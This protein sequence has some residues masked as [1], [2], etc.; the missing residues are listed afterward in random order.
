MFQVQIVH[1]EE[2]GTILAGD[3]YSGACWRRA[4]IIH[5][6]GRAWQLEMCF[7]QS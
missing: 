3:L 4:W 5:E 7:S 6:I 2:I 1:E